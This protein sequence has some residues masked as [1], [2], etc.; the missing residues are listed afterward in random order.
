MG[1]LARKYTEEFKAGA[2]KLVLQ[3]PGKGC[4]TCY[5]LNAV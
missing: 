3:K 1:K 5:R 4:V 2:I